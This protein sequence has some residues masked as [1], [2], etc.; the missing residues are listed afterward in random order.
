MG[1]TLA[2]IGLALLVLVGL[3]VVHYA[4][5]I[6]RGREEPEPGGSLGDQILGRRN[7]PRTK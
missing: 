4:W 7:R 6:W 2:L 5:R 3:G 1:Y